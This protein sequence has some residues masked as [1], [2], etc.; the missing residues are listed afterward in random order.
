MVA[1][2]MA[3]VLRTWAALA[4][5]DE[6]GNV[7]GAQ[8]DVDG[9]TPATFCATSDCSYAPRPYCAGTATLSPHVTPACARRR[10]CRW[11]TRPGAMTTRPA[12]LG[13]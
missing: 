4:Y 9:V 3:Q 2:G 5:L 6:Q 8:V 13:P 1:I 10:G 7:I 12:T 11:P